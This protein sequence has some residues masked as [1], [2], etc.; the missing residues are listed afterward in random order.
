MDSR[1]QY[2]LLVESIKLVGAPYDLRLSTLPDYVDVVFEIITGYEDTFY[3]LPGLIEDDLLSKKAV[4]SLIKLFT[5]INIT[6]KDE[7]L[8]T[9]EALRD[10][11]RR[12]EIRLYAKETLN[13][14]EELNSAPNLSH[15]AWVQGK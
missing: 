2:K 10:H 11:P 8:C 7:N 12:K 4:V 13:T 14:L 6:A 1:Q 5:D 15:I 9:V 3:L